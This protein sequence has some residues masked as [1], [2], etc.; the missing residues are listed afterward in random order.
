MLVTQLDT[1]PWRV[2]CSRGSASQD[3]I[4]H[5]IFLRDD[6]GEIELARS[7]EGTPSDTWPCSPPLQQLVADTLTD[8]VQAL[9]GVGLA[10]KSHWSASIHVE[11]TGRLVIDMA[12]RC[13]PEFQYLGSRYDA[14]EGVEV[15]KVENHLMLVHPKAKGIV[16]PISDVELCIVDGGWMAKAIIPNA[17]PTMNKNN[18]SSITVRW[19]FGLRVLV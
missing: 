10:G 18:G 17:A 5:G 11:P 13:S 7:R 19:A 4:S 12:C 3:R 15:S 2:V 8:G 6:H 1:F 9:L 16:E 14:A